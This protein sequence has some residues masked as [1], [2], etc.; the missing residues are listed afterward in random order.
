MEEDGNIES[1]RDAGWEDTFIQMKVRNRKR[2]EAGS[3]VSSYRPREAKMRKWSE[4]YEGGEVWGERGLAME[5]TSFLYSKPGRST[6][7]AGG[8][9]QT[10]IRPLK[11]SET[12]AGWMLTE[13]LERVQIGLELEAGWE[14]EEW[15]MKELEAACGNEKA[16]PSL[17]KPAECRV[18]KAT[19]A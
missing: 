7:G 6:G 11:L 13:V 10:K 8:M 3:Y 9:V 16:D 2:K 12:I 15:M 4:R 1:K 14:D 5:T 17:T 19:P 18:A